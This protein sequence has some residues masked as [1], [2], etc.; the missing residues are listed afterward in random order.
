[1]LSI[2]VQPGL[3]HFSYD[4]VG[5]KGRKNRPGWLAPDK[6]LSNHL[7]FHNVLALSKEWRNE[8]LHGH[9]GEPFPFSLLKGQPVFWTGLVSRCSPGINPTWYGGY[10]LLLHHFFHLPMGH[11]RGNI[12]ATYEIMIYAKTTGLLGGSPQLINLL[13]ATPIYKP[14]NG[15]L[16]GVP[17]CPQLGLWD[18]PAGATLEEL[19]LRYAE[20]S[21]TYDHLGVRFCPS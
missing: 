1:M 18:R 4:M 14:W 17:R 13:G 8:V 7:S 15:Q 20:L 21:P 6:M 3:F 5:A 11:P 19:Q 10:D 12:L 2:H 16:E 9:N